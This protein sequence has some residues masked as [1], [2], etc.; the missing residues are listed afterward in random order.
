MVVGWLPAYVIV[1]LSYS[2]Q[3]RGSRFQ[4]ILSPRD[5]TSYRSSVALLRQ[6]ADFLFE[7]LII[8]YFAGRLLTQAS[9][10]DPSPHD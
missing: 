7:R 10:R 9:S 6:H 4:V 8:I 2:I 3:S 5:F 1:R